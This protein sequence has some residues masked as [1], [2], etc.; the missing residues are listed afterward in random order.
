MHYDD[1]SRRLNLVGGLLAGI[2]LGLGLTLLLAPP[3]R[4]RAGRRK[5]GRGAKRLRRVARRTA[6][7][8]RERAAGVGRMAVRPFRL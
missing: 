1:R 8:A 4:V 7:G 3:R 6:G 5:L 2:A